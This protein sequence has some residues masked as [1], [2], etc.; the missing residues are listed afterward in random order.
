VNE[1]C[2]RAAVEVHFPEALAAA[3][4]SGGGGV[5]SGAPHNED[6]RALYKLLT[7]LPWHACHPAYEFGNNGLV[8][9]RLYPCV[10]HASA[11]QA[12]GVCSLAASSFVC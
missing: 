4:G 2:W 5:S 10:R 9:E 8:V 11:R 1:Q 3:C 6:W 12:T 7:V